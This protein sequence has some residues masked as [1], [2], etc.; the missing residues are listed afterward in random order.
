MEFSFDLQHTLSAIID[1][2]CIGAL[3]FVVAYIKKGCSFFKALVEKI[4]IMSRALRH[5]TGEKLENRMTECLDRGHIRP[6]EAKSI[7]DL[8]ESYH[9][10]EGNSHIDSLH[11]RY[12]ALN[13]KKD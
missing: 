10:L 4:E 1:A 2:V 5:I 8:Y 12:K 6:T 11:E 3:G 13:I 7:D 9:D